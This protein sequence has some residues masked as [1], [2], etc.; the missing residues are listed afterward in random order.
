M[1]LT[2]DQWNDVYV[3]ITSKQCHTS[4][5]THSWSSCT[6]THTHTMC[7]QWTSRQANTSILAL[8]FKQAISIY[9]CTLI[10]IIYGFIAISTI[11]CICIT[12]LHMM[13]YRVQ[14]WWTLYASIHSQM[15]FDYALTK[16]AIPFEKYAYKCTIYVYT[17]MAQTNA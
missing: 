5:P 11:N 17:F 1:Y 7:P 12:E 6:H 4:L 16:V 10:L 2:Y 14:F 13:K 9:I 15:W 3:I 8:P